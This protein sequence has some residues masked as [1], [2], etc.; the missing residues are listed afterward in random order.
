MKVR[1]EYNQGDS[2]PIVSTFF[3]F[4]FFFFRLSSG[5]YSGIFIAFQKERVQKRG[6]WISEIAGIGL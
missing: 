1:L 5:I 2:S 6:A 4:F 3:F